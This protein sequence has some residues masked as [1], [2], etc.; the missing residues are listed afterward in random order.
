MQGVVTQDPRVGTLRT[1][2]GGLA[3]P[4][5]GS[6]IN[7]DWSA[8]CLLWGSSDFAQ[9]PT[10]GHCGF[11]PCDLRGPV[12]HKKGKFYDFMFYDCVGLK[13]NIIHATVL[14]LLLLSLS[15]DLKVN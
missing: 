13:T 11:R 7:P 12:S 15:S 3:T 6:Y 4:A 9:T 1:Q 2:G 14:Y 5:E 8:L 10:P